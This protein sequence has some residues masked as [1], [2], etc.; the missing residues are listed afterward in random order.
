MLFGA[1]GIDGATRYAELLASVGVERGLVGPHE[2][3]RV[4]E[5]HLLNSA[6]IHEAIPGG[7]V[8]VDIGS[9][10]GLPGIPLAL[11]RPDL[12]VHLVEPMM[13]RTA[14]LTGVVT[15]LR[16]SDRVTVHRGRAEDLR[17]LEADVV[18]S[19]AVAPLQK[20]LPWC[21]RWC[22]RGGHVIALKGEQAAAELAN[23]A[24]NVSAWGLSDVHVARFGAGVVSPP[25]MAV[26]ATRIMDQLHERR[27][28]IGPARGSRRERT[29]HASR[30]RP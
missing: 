13:R 18:V 24:D 16:L 28:E 23:V 5:R 10:A 11:A 1:A 7:A 19:R 26:M 14:W 8:V 12:T 25:T 30:H 27:P 6:V 3:P 4:W 17:P 15:E 2:G 20:L 29:G 22:R 21:A 9:G